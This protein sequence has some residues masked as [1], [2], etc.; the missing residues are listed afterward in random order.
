ML[1][2]GSLGSGAGNLRLSG[3]IL[4]V[5]DGATATLDGLLWV[6]GGRIQGAGE[7]RLLG[8]NVVS[9]GTL[10]HNIRNQGTLRWTGGSIE[11][12][13]TN[14]GLLQIDG[15]EIRYLYGLLNNAGTVI[16]TASGPI[17]GSDGVISNLPEGVY[18]FQQGFLQPW[19]GAAGFINAGVLRKTTDATATIGF[20]ADNTNGSIE[21]DAGRLDLT[22]TF[23][24]FTNQRLE[25]GSYSVT[26]EL[27]FINADV[28]SNA[29]QITQIGP[30]AAIRST[31]GADALQALATNEAGAVLTITDGAHLS[32]PP[33]F[34]NEGTVHVGSGSTFLPAGGYLQTAGETS[35]AQ[36]GTIF[37]QGD[38]QLTGGSLTGNG[39]VATNVVNTAGQVSPGIDGPGRLRIEGN[40]T[41]E[42]GASLAIDIAGTEVGLQY[43]R[44]EVTGE[45]MASSGAVDLAGTLAVT[46]ADSYLPNQADVFDVLTFTSQTGDFSAITGTQIGPNRALIP[47]LS[48]NAYSLTSVV[49]GVRIE[50]LFG[51]QTMENGGTDTFII[52]LEAAPSS[53]VTIALSSNNPQEAA[54]APT[55][56]TFTSDNWDVPQ[57]VVVTGLDDFVDDG[58]TPYS[59]VTAP[60]VSDDPLFSGLNASDVAAVNVNDDVAGFTLGT[61][62]SPQTTEAGGSSEFTVVLDSQPLSDV[63]LA[64]T[65]SDEK[66]G[67]PTPTSL[68]FTAE[69]W[70]E[71]QTVAVVGQDDDVVDGQVEYT[72]QVSV[73]ETSDGKY[74]NLT[75]QSFGLSNVDN[76]T[77]GIT[78]VAP[79]LLETTEAGGQSTFTIV[80]DSQPRHNVSIDLSSSNAQEGVVTP[81]SVT[82]TPGTW[83]QPRT[84]TVTGQGDLENDG[85]IAYEILFSPSISDDPLY[86]G[87]ALPSIPAI[88]RDLTTYDLAVTDWQ[89]PT[90]VVA[91]GDAQISVTW[92]VTNQ[93]GNEIPASA[94][95]EDHIVLSLDD[96]VGNDDDQVLRSVAYIDGF[97]LGQSLAAGQSYSRQADITLPS[98]VAGTVNLYVHSDA[99]DAVIELDETN[100]IGPL[101]PVDVVVLLPDLNVEFVTT[102]AE[103][104]SGETIPVSWRVGNQGERAAEGIWVDRVYLSTDQVLD[105]DDVVLTSVTRNTPLAVNSTYTQQTDVTLP[106]DKAGTFYLLVETDAASDLV[107]ADEANNVTASL[108]PITITFAPTPDLAITDVTANV[109]LVQPQQPIE[110]GWTVTNQGED[111]AKAPWSDRVYLSTDGTLNGA[112][113]LAT[114]TRDTH[115]PTDES[116]TVSAEVLLPVVPDGDYQIVVVADALNQVYEAE[117]EDNN[118]YVATQLLT[119]VHAD[120]VSEVTAGVNQATSGDTLTLEWIT[121]NIGTGDTLTGFLDRVYLSQD[122]TVDTNDRLLGEV[123]R[124][125]PLA[126][127]TSLPTSLD[128]EIP[129][130]VSGDWFVLVKADADNRIVEPDE[131]N[132]ASAASI[133]ISLA[134][135]ADLVVSAVEAPPMT[136]GDPAV[137]TISWTVRNVGTG[138]GLT[139]RWTDR[140]VASSDPVLGNSDD[141]ILG[142]F[143][144]SGELA[145]GDQYSREQT[146]LLPDQLQGRY[147]LFVQTDANHEVF[148]N[149]SEANNSLAAAD[150]FDVMRVPYADLIVE[151]VT[152][153]AR[154][155]SGQ[156]YRLS[157]TVANVGIGPTDTDSWSDL[158]RVSHDAEN[159]QP[160]ALPGSDNG[161]VV[162]NH[163]GRLDTDGRYTRSIDVTLPLDLEGAIY[164]HVSTGGPFEFIYN[165]NN[166]A[167]SGPVEVTL[168]P[169]PD[170]AVTQITAPTNASVGQS[171]DVEWTVRNDG[172]GSATGSWT[173]KL[174]LRQRATRTL[175]PFRW[176]PSTSRAM[177]TRAKLIRAAS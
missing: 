164:F 72:I 78:V 93:S 33:G 25:G 16:H 68:T 134:P 74:A 23:A 65:S 69:N 147:F 162:A 81:A 95:W 129:V 50:P 52:Q 110:I 27:R 169:V 120:L 119:V 31:A 62:D 41:Q 48:E 80:L 90:Q 112:T 11:H 175:S 130:D 42:S 141:R 145:V 174:F 17:R 160:I 118:Q 30:T 66:E 96:I 136:V 60:A 92:S 82:F 132:N 8:E 75:S 156:A 56:V 89:V 36:G 177:W 127:G 142:E 49:A 29:A 32:P 139:T 88:N 10:V 37:P 84:I 106:P 43:D 154:A 35:T 114:R 135:F 109:T 40:Y 128:L 45:A 149:A 148:E 140:V 3:G 14:E 28:R 107:E 166:S 15:P 86:S 70:N 77:A 101:E 53:P 115:L 168:A 165:D 76:D 123:T 143:P 172:V 73:G 100:N 98:E 151:S 19:G 173:D 113:L 26:G 138:V 99:T 22:G 126:V 57:E 83:N 34:T 103:A 67:A 63:V 47:V 150:L 124:N 152:G 58:D 117:D 55:E 24:N 91:E 4:S 5:P 116:Y 155:V 39:V 71:A 6:D 105:G 46:I 104:Q 146:I 2:D 51:L 163:L 121:R 137:A 9:A 44:L 79:S 1:Q 144:H 108:Q 171:M 64:I 13:V 38:F 18:E 21:V 111:E 7:L 85:D 159:Q 157:W 54:I 131:S 167:S 87:I 170:L 122:G 102:D 12:I 59:I 176:V 97:V 158:V 20:S 161:V 61:P 94:V 153:S 133:S 125:L